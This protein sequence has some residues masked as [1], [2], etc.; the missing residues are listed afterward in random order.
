MTIVTS[1][2]LANFSPSAP[3]AG[4]GPVRSG[5]LS[6]MLVAIAV[7]GTGSAVWSQGAPPSPNYTTIPGYNLS[8]D[9]NPVPSA[10]FHHSP[11]RGNVLIHDVA[12]QVA[13]VVDARQRQVSQFE[14]KDFVAI[15]GGELEPV[16]GSTAK[17]VVPM[18]L[19]EKA[20]AFT[21]D[22]VQYRVVPKPSLL[23]PQTSAQIIA[24]DPY[25]GSAAAR[26]EVQPT[27][28]DKLKATQIPTRVLMFFG[29]WCRNCHQ[30][31]PNIIKLEQELEGSNITFEYHGLPQGYADPVA[32]SLNVRSVP[33]GVVFQNGEEI[34][35]VAGPSWKF[36]GLALSRALP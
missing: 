33:F 24:D 26:F 5:L 23:G 7:L 15:P 32:Q 1:P 9:G 2:P 31:L 18:R 25:Y 20:P 17:S 8:A 19:V 13:F 27:Y 16:A 4:R 36:P 30:W 29:S 6:I 3:A 14:A 28:L 10:V 21:V 22:G 34:A 35:R 12:N 11:G